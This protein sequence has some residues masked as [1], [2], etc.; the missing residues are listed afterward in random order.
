MNSEPK[1]EASGHVTAMDYESEENSM[2]IT[3]TSAPGP[4]GWHDLP[5]YSGYL[6]RPRDETNDRLEFP[7][8]AVVRVL[9]SPDDAAHAPLIMEFVVPS[10]AMTTVA[11]VHPRQAE[12]YAVRE[13]SLEVFVAGSWSTV[14]AGQSATVPAGTPHAFRNRSGA[15][16]RF[17]NEHR[18]ALRFEEYF[19]TVHW[20]AEDGLIKGSFD[21]R[22]VLYACVLMEEYG[23][24][25]RPSGAIQ[26]GAVGMLAAVGRL[27]GIDVRQ[28]AQTR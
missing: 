26:R 8:G 9:E 19:R 12:T 23:D 14:E 5:P 28:F 24:T 6:S 2:N 20:L 3:A 27:L 13:G 11:H 21:I 4:S 15:T 25:M 22:G 18:P 1:I 7:D 17:L 10:E 16:V